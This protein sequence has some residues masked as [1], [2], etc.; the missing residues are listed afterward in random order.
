MTLANGVSKRTDIWG[1]LTFEIRLLDDETSAEETI[2]LQA[3][4][5][6]ELRVW[7]NALNAERTKVTLSRLLFIHF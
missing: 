5:E 4:T 7:M 2:C 1:G 6:E 3:E